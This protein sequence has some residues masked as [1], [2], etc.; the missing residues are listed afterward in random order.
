M[1]LLPAH[2]DRCRG[3]G[4]HSPLATK[5]LWYL[6]T[7]S[8]S[9]YSHFSLHPA[10]QAAL[11]QCFWNFRGSTWIT[12]GS[13]QNA[14][15]DS[16]EL[17][18]LADLPLSWSPKWCWGHGSQDPAWSP[19]SRADWPPW[20]HPQL[21][22]CLRVLFCYLSSSSLCLSPWKYFWI[23]LFSTQPIYIYISPWVA[24][25]QS[26]HYSEAKVGPGVSVRISPLWLPKP[27]PCLPESTSR[28]PHQNS[29]AQCQRPD[30]GCIFRTALPST[31]RREQVAHHVSGYP[32][33]AWRRLPN[34]RE[35]A[36][37]FHPTGQLY[38]KPQPCCHKDFGCV[39]F[40]VSDQGALPAAL[41]GPSAEHFLCRKVS[42]AHCGATVPS[43][44]PG[45][46]WGSSF[47]RSYQTSA[48][49][50]PLQRCYPKA[51]T[52]PA[53]L[54]ISYKPWKAKHILSSGQQQGANWGAGKGDERKTKTKG[55]STQIQRLKGVNT[56]EVE[57]VSQTHAVSLSLFHQNYVSNWNFAQTRTLTNYIFP[58]NG[59]D[60]NNA[61]GIPNWKQL[62]VSQSF[63]NHNEIRIGAPRKLSRCQTAIGG[64][65]WYSP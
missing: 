60:C 31:L 37:S 36:A 2:L 10:R 59:A 42:Q 19:Q 40:L 45:S 35:Q 9:S 3:I 17:G 46:T 5:P 39:R 18:C 52:N 51:I 11:M 33:A 20:H 63:C 61:H 38:V 54:I 57:L 7:G 30:S 65:S 12:S 48:S 53:E 4:K 14:E 27:S 49:Q 29:S 62:G 55:R 25:V 8:K 28:L 26:P 47:R 58:H 13:C 64:L 43:Q 23:N 41:P 24:H 50:S 56:R 22:S 16:A 44:A 32:R 21:F 15:S 6:N 34:R 1:S